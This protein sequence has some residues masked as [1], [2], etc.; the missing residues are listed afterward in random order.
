MKP[1]D[2]ELHDMLIRGL[3]GMIKAY[4]NW[5]NKKKERAS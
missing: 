4:E 1:E 3:K 5:L 2:F